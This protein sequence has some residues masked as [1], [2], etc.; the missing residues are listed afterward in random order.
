MAQEM[1]PAGLVPLPVCSRF[2]VA[3]G[4]PNVVRRIV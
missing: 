1:Y 3:E 4:I 2:D